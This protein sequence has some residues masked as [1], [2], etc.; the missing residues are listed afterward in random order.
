MDAGGE[1]RD[2]NNG[3]QHGAKAWHRL[4]TR[5]VSSGM[6]PAQRHI[7]APERGARVADGTSTS[8]TSTVPF[9]KAEAHGTAWIGRQSAGWRSFHGERNP[10]RCDPARK[11]AISYTSFTS[12]RCATV[13]WL[14]ST[15]SDVT[16]RCQTSTLWFVRLARKSRPSRIA[17]ATMIEVRRQRD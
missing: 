17:S 10:H 4:A 8:S 6:I 9:T 12:A 16:H 1:Q 5:A 11:R 3:K 15:S 14:R 13:R 7:R 2:D